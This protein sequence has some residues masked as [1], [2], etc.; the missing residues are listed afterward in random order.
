MSEA[1]KPATTPTATPATA[2]EKTASEERATR[3]VALVTGASSGIGEALAKL[4]GAEGFDLVLTARRTDRL[5]ALQ[6]SLAESGG[7][8]HVVSADLADPA[9]LQRLYDTLAQLDVEID[10]LV[11]NAGMM[12][13]QDNANFS[14][15]AIADIHR[16]LA[17][18]VT[19]LTSLTHHFLQQMRARDY[20]RI[21]NVA[22]MAAFHP[23]AGMDVYAA[24]KAYV[25]SLS[26]SLSEQ[27]RGTG[28]SVTTLCP[29]LT[30]TDMI[31]DS[32]LRNVPSFFIQSPE[33]VAREGFDALMNRE[34][35]RIPGNVNKLAVTWAQ[36]QPRWLVRGL[37]GIAARFGLRG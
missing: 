24:S 27:V 18:N 1:Q 25:L 30:E 20:G 6:A 10:L 33:T 31:D 22:S 11:N 17:L 19:A 14:D 32:L 23:M 21:L 7:Q 5:E 35:V 26:E 37:G 12:I 3:G 4:L 9:G 16:L 28:V 34:A 36:H 15:L 13:Q 8:T 2:P 29:G